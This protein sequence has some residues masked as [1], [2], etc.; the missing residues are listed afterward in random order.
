M[1]PLSDRNPT[2]HRAYLTAAL[3]VLNVFVFV[4]VQQR[5]GDETITLP[6]G[7]AAT[8]DAEVRFTLEY[9]A[10]PC[11]LTQGRPLD[12]LEIQALARGD[13][14]EC[15]PV[16]GVQLFPGKNVWFSAIASMFLHAGWVHLGFNMLFLWIFGNNIED[17]LG[18][19]KFVAFY[20]LSGVA[21][22]ATHVFLQ[23]DSAVPLV[24][25]SGAVAGVMGAY[26]IWFPRAPIRTL[27][28]FFIVEVRAIWWLSAWFVFQFFTA[29]DSEVAWAAHVGGFAFGVFV[30]ALIRQIRPLCRWAWRE[31]WRS[32]AYYRWDLSG[33]APGPVGRP[34]FGRRSW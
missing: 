28:L 13:S 4:F 33:G 30:A 6:D 9:A 12:L 1:L 22:L 34:R 15:D 8:I 19:V 2:H 3:I 29:S 27:L 31:P 23:V 21:A 11:E 26:L 25:A 32:N 10:I 14:Q 17:H 20:V 24:G 7:R 18:P 5:P 16:D